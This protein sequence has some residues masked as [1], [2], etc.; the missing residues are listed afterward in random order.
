MMEAW[1]GQE[2]KGD[3][4][5]TG[6]LNGEEEKGKTDETRTEKG[7]DERNMRGEG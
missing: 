7:G 1:S 5:V 6:Q 4:G 3:K 2:E